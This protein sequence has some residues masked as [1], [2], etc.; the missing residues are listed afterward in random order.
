M[1][2]SARQPQRHGTEAAFRLKSNLL[3]SNLAAH[4][5]KVRESPTGCAR[6]LAKTTLSLSL[7][8]ALAMASFFAQMEKS[9]LDQVALCS[10]YKKLFEDQKNGTM[11]NMFSTHLSITNRDLDLLRL[12]MK[13]NESLP[14]YKLETVT[15]NC[16]PINV[17][18]KERELQL[19]IRTSK[20]A[21]PD[22]AQI[23]VI[24][25]F[26]FSL[27][28]QPMSTAI[29]R[30]FHHVKLEPKNLICCSVDASRQ[31]DIIHSTDRKPFTNPDSE[32]LEFD[33]P[34]LFT[35]NKGKS[36]THK[37]K[38][39]PIKLTFYQ[40][41]YLLKSD[42]KLGTVQLKVDSINDEARISTKQVIMNGRK[43]TGAFAD[44]QIKVW[45]PLVENT[46]RA[47]EEKLLILS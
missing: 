13:N 39:K 44:I 16:V 14:K 28:D 43:D 47:H 27:N 6:A 29:S 35:V 7:S 8:L 1:H 2:W 12:A 31:L 22:N 30:W 20:L 32:W 37:R 38:F 41:T 17:D 4:S 25:E 3:P 9:L 18:V 45:K 33:K 23:Y 42:K 40:K 10:Y 24:G 21:V 34:M 11:A 15:F 36:R 26:S 19:V 46:I 5:E